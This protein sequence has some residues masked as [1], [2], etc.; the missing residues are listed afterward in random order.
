MHRSLIILLF[1][2]VIHSLFGQS[3]EKPVWMSGLDSLEA[4]F[5][6]ETIDSLKFDLLSEMVDS[7]ERYDR[8]Q[9][10]PYI[11]RML[12]FSLEANLPKDIATSYRTFGENYFYAGVND[13]ALYYF[14]KA[15]E[16]Y[17]ELND[18]DNINHCSN[19]LALI[20]QNMNQ[21]EKAIEEYQKLISFSR[22]NEKYYFAIL[23]L[24]NLSTLVA[25]QEDLARSISYLK[26]VD[27]LYELIED[28]D[29]KE[30]VDRIYPSILVNQGFNYLELA[31][32]SEEDKEASAQFVDTALTC[33]ESALL[34]SN[35]LP[36]GFSRTYLASFANSGLG[37][38]H[39]YQYEQGHSVSIADRASSDQG[40]LDL[41][42]ALMNSAIE[43]FSSLQTQWELASCKSNLG[44]ILSA[45]GRYQEAQTVLLEA[46]TLA[47][48]LEYIEVERDVYNHLA[49]VSEELGD[50][51]NAYG[52]V[53][54]YTEL[55]KEIINKA[56]M[57]E[58]EKLQ[59]QFQTQ[60]LE[61]QNKELNLKT[62]E[63]QRRQRLWYIIFAVSLIGVVGLA[64]LLYTR[65]RL[66]QEKKAAE[67][68]RE[69]STAMA[70]FVPHEF[71]KTIGRD[72]I[73][74]VQLGDQIEKEVTVLFT[75]I[76]S[77]TSIS[78]KM[79]PF[80][81]FNFVKTYAERMGPIIQR[82]GGFIN[83][84]LGDGI[85]AIFQ[86]SPKDALNACIEMQQ[87]I[88]DYNKELEK[89][90]QPL[91]RVGMGMH[92]GPLVM[93]IIGDENRRDAAMISDTVNTAA[94]MES[95]TKEYGADILLSDSSLAGLGENKYHVKNLGTVHVKG[96]ELPVVI[97]E[98]TNHRA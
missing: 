83:Q 2:L 24:A 17:E 12:S 84:Y 61:Y 96:K 86:N 22:R 14:E 48:D 18:V 21:Y 57:E 35:E 92:T 69:L 46:Q 89:A 65:Y 90:N 63:Q 53:R 20:Y 45:K 23:G 1:S 85:M 98:C 75:D 71:I 66:R 70:R 34:Q 76:R 62:E 7:V 19:N 42:E 55:D 40:L 78:E 72:K 38:S 49:S 26:E 39:L 79:T 13:T 82:N 4:R 80:E 15:S 30:E 73:V 25:E 74:D 44:K 91:V 54:L 81:N 67:F 93:G 51:T 33:F 87:D 10:F 64:I 31:R 9:T 68:E 58:N 11:Q 32:G 5:E 94:R 77:F 59:V 60:E 27:E 56:R 88:V 6:E 37:E 47:K 16:M 8:S 29:E 95:L 52:Y 28:E 36:E 41:A 97:Y 43:G 3:E 50:F